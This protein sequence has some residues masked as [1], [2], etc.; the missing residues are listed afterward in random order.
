MR[1]IQKKKNKQQQGFTLIELIIVVAIIGLLAAIAVPLY[2][3]QLSKSYMSQVRA[4]SKN[5]YTTASLFF[6]DYPDAT[7]ITLSDI[8][9]RGYIQT[10]AVTM[11]V[12]SGTQMTFSLVGSCTNA[13]HCTGSYQIDASGQAIDTLDLPK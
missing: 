12:N 7:A 10:S 11:S 1:L 2:H 3:S 5:A 6:S 13:F 8:A 9:S 4:A